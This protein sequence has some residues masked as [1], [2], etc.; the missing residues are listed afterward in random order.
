MTLTRDLSCFNINTMSNM[1]YY[2]LGFLLAD[3]HFRYNKAIIPTIELSVE[4]SNKDLEHLKKLLI[5]L[6]RD[7][8]S[9]TTRI[10]QTKVCSFIQTHVS[11][12]ISDNNELVKLVKYFDI[13]TN[14]TIT[15]PDI[16]IYSQLTKI[17]KQCLLI[18][19][20]DGDGHIRN[21]RGSCDGK[22]ECHASWLNIYNLFNS[23]LQTQ[24]DVKEYF[25][26][27]KPGKSSV[28]LYL[29]SKDIFSLFEVAIREQLPI[30]E[31]K[32]SCINKALNYIPQYTQ[33]ETML[34]KQQ[35]KDLRLTNTQSQLSAL[36]GIT[37][38]RV[39]YIYKLLGKDDM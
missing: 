22:L 23:I 33:K 7:E 31:R 16:T 18:G 15:P 4:L 27:D 19:Y 2:W 13:H 20:I 37:K 30:L 3:G 10:R 9:Y 5:F 35:V 24:Y 29:S 12:R 32:W 14:K 11:F 6:G 28:I 26:K 34:L 38:D 17:Q 8:N 36:L 21:K 25:R 39:K 1:A